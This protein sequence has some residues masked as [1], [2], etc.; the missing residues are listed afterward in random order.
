MDNL[1]KIALSRAVLATISDIDSN[2]YPDALSAYNALVSADGS[3][4]TIP[5]G[6][7]VWQPFEHWELSDVLAHIDAEAESNLDMIKNTLDY[8]KAGLVQSAIDDKLD[9]DANSWHLEMMVDIGVAIENGEYEDE[10][11]NEDEDEDEN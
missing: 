5:E 8:A 4:S 11:E 10:D 9:S 1:K 7:S 2:L 3:G 6:M